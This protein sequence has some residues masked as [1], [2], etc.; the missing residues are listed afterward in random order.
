ML[1]PYVRKYYTR[2]TLIDYDEENIE[3]GSI[4]SEQYINEECKKE[5]CG[6][7]FDGRCRY[8]ESND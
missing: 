8:N 5:K 3:K 7:W 6:A 1:C 2:V 4:I